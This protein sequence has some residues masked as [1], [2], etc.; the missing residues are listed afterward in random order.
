MNDQYTLSMKTYSHLAFVNVACTRRHGPAPT[1]NLEENIFPV[2]VVQVCVFRL[3]GYCEHDNDEV[4][5]KHD[6][7]LRIVYIFRQNYLIIALTHCITKLQCVC[8]VSVR[9]NR[10]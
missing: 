4:K 5:H 8:A 9:V 3:R 1:D 2:P 10:P 6:R 7:H